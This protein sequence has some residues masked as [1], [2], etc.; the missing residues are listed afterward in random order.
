[1]CDKHSIN[2]WTD[3]YHSENGLPKVGKHQGLLKKQQQ[4]YNLYNKDIF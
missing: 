3:R 4:R 1:M 2:K